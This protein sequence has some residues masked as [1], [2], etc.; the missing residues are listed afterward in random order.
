MKTPNSKEIRQLIDT[1]L[2]LQWCRENIVCPLS[3]H[4]ES[5]TGQERPGTTIAIGNFSYLAT[6]GE[7]IKHRFES[8]GHECQFIELPESEISRYLD[9]ASQHRIISQKEEGER[10]EFNDNKI[11]KAIQNADE[12]N[13]INKNNFDFDDSDVETIDNL[14]APDISVEMLGTK[15]QQAAAKILI[16]CARSGVS[17]ISLDP[18]EES[19]QVRIRR[20]GIMQNYVSMPRSA[21]IKLTA[22]LKN[23]ADMD[24]AE[25]RVS[26][27]GKIKRSFEG[28]IMEWRCFTASAKYGELLIMH[29]KDSSPNMLSLDLL[30]SNKK[31]CNN[32]RSLINQ[33]NGIIIFSGPT[34]S[35]K[36]TTCASALQEL[37]TGELRILTAEDPIE[38][39]LG[40]SIQQFPV[41][42]A[43]GDTFIDKLSTLIRLDPD[44]ILLGELVDQETGIYL[45][46]LAQTG[47]LILTTMDAQN[48][49]DAITD[50]IHMEVPRHKINTS[51]RA[52][53]SQRLLRRVCPSC[54]MERIINDV[55]SQ[56][57]ELPAGT[58]VRFAN[59][60]SVEEK[61]KR[62]EEGTLCEHCIGTGYQGRVA[63]YELLKIDDNIREAIRSKKSRN[64]IESIA[65]SN[66][67]LT[68]KSYAIDLVKEHLTTISELEK[69]CDLEV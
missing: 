58:T 69:L 9:E 43:K 44:V 35:G 33:S 38:Y 24:I 46:E 15:I 23:M 52:V 31:I 45:T 22:C 48:S 66:G 21:G 47:H 34:G 68:L 20:D 17:N 65:I 29:F 49:S 56:F 2:S 51:I 1:Y 13:R 64:E 27:T 12:E 62:K 26:Q 7:F 50:L 6:I 10:F 41:V 11:I 30:V 5:L 55:E 60:L 28:D 59:A 40:G 63:T 67:M 14:E 53:L 36:G 4:T 3:N 25:R 39:E 32:L 61:Q 18:L 16:N 42:R 54:S 57:T 19:Y 37:D 8:Y